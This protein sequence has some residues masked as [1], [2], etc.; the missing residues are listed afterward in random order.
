M[1]AEEEEYRL[2]FS[3]MDSEEEEYRLGAHRLLLMPR[4]GFLSQLYFPSLSLIF[5][6][7]LSSYFLFGF[8][9]TVFRGG[10]GA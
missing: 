8:P 10:G 6:F 2:G 5:I 7:F 9:S 4:T 3:P 1:K